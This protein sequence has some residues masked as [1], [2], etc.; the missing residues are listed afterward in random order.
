LP[1]S[2]KK[3]GRVANACI[4][5]DRTSGSADGLALESD[6]GIKAISFLL[7]GVAHDARSWI[8]G[9]TQ[10]SREPTLHLKKPS[11]IPVAIAAL[12]R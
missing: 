7:R 9:D 6:I 11:G 12:T 3:T 5:A 2:L 10:A 8:V 4:R 1:A